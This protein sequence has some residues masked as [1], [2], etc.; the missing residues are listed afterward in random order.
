MRKLDNQDKRINF[1]QSTL[2]ILTLN[3][4][5]QY[6][7]IQYNT[8]LSLHKI[9]IFMSIPVD[10]IFCK[11]SLFR[12]RHSA[13]DPIL[14]QETKRCQTPLRVISIHE[15]FAKIYFFVKMLHLYIGLI[16]MQPKR[17]INRKRIYICRYAFDV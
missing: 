6:N 9:H 2:K 14:S 7:T 5:I 10:L 12:A 15:K 3:L 4:I 17:S 16:D 11:V 13:Q 8:I 1:D